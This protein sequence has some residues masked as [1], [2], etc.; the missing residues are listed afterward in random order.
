VAGL[1]VRHDQNPDRVANAEK[2]LK[3]IAFPKASSATPARLSP[4]RRRPVARSAHAAS[5][6][7][8]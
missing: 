1:F 3:N 7:R 5:F 4:R 8:S 2:M 6:L